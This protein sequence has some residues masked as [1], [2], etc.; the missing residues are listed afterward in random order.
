MHT[1]FRDC[2]AWLDEKLPMNTTSN[3]ASRLYDA[4]LTQLVGF[5]DD[6]KL[7]GLLGSL[8]SMVNE[9]PDFILGLCL[10]YGFTLFGANLLLNSAE[11]RNNT[12]N[13]AKKALNL[14][15]R[16]TTRELMHVKAIEHLQV[17][18]LS[19]AVDYWEDILLENPTD[20]LALKFAHTAYFYM[21]SGKE[22]SD[23]VARVI[24]LWSNST[25]LY[26]YLHGMYAFGLTQINKLTQAESAARKAL[27]INRRDTWATHAISHV[28]EYNG[29]HERGIQ[30]LLETENDWSSCAH[31]VPHNY[32]HL[33]LYYLEKSEYEKVIDILDTKLKSD[34]ANGASLM[35]RLK[36]DG[37]N[38][39]ND[40]LDYCWRDLKEKNLERIDNQ[41]YMYGGYHMAMVLSACGT[42]EEK[43][44]YFKSLDDYVSSNDFDEESLL[45]SKVPNLIG[46]TVNESTK[47]SIKNFLKNVN[48]DL[49]FNLYSS[50]FDY[51][52]GDYDN[53]VEKLYPIRYKIYRAGGSNAQRDIFNMILLQSAIRSNKAIYN[54]LGLSL[55]NER[56]ASKPNSNFTTRLA[57]KLTIDE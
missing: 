10:K 25:P 7:D 52:N 26:G 6:P 55:L 9:D 39:S 8:E 24:P 18:N 41:G 30:F 48:N 20:M 53:V 44:R 13:L 21:G 43:S 33:A 51:N 14:G 34:L 57:N 1:N 27:E 19:K 5:Y 31:L 45:D 12:S 54:K 50:V 23:S 42:E 35:L 29:E 3:E 4:A 32:W 28:N 2:K 15:S 49:A 38:K 11:A 40:L 16:I 56:Q 22:I 17:G 37:Y 36:M 46:S 47:S